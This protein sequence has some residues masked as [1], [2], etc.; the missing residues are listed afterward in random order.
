MFWL[1]TIFFFCLFLFLFYYGCAWL[2]CVSVLI[3]QPHGCYNSI[4]A[5][6]YVTGTRIQASFCNFYLNIYLSSH[7]YT[8]F[9]LTG[10]PWEVT[11][12][13]LASGCYV[14]HFSNTVLGYM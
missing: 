4:N 3:I 11:L 5:K 10:R 6:C 8:L 7:H 13:W 14:Y 1:F 9:N 12:I 2:C